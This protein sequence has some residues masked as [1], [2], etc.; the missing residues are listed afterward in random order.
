MKQKREGE[1]EE[2]SL[3][4]LSKQNEEKREEGKKLAPQLNKTEKTETFVV[5]NLSAG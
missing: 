5:V 3:V 4:I 1:M 2:T